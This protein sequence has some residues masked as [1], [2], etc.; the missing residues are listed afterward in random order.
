MAPKLMTSEMNT[1]IKKSV[2]LIQGR[3]VAHTP[4]DTGRLRSSH[5]SIFTNLAGEIGTHT[6]Y[7]IYVH[8]GTRFM[9]A[10]PYLREAVQESNDQVN[11]FFTEAVDNVLSAI[12]KAT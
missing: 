5:R 1:A 7:D 6:N 10:R 8:D 4:V 3:S 9:R 11:Q 2:F 12:G